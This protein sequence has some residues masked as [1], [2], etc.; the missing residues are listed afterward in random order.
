M[1]CKVK[2]SVAYTIEEVERMIPLLASIAVSIKRVWKELL[3]K[4]TRLAEL[5]KAF[6][7]SKPKPP[8]RSPWEPPS[9]EDEILPAPR[10][11][12]QELLDLRV[13]CSII[14]DVLI[15]YVKEVEKLGGK[16][17]T[18]S[19]PVFLF[20][21]YVKVPTVASS[22]HHYTRP[23]HL[24]WKDGDMEITSWKARPS[25]FPTPI[26]DRSNFS[27]ERVTV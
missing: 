13:E 8:R 5:E 7:D 10:P 24:V 12:P 2:E 3:P 26:R 21:T 16:V 19:S 22:A 27:W 20:P 6:E 23:A 9:E 4:R 25:D 1:V 11:T 18:F 15:S 17:D 14:Q